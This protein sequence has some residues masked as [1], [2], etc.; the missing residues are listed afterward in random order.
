MFSILKRLLNEKKY[1]CIH[2]DE[3]SPNKFVFGKIIGV[4]TNNVAISMVSPDGEYDGVLL[5]QI[6]DI[7]RVEQSVSYENKMRKLMRMK[8]YDEKEFAIPNENIL[9]GILDFAKETGVIISVELDHSGIDDVAG[10][11]ES[12]NDK[13]CELIQVNEYGEEDGESF[14]TLSDISQICLD[15]SDE[16]RLLALFQADD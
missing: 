3:T 9:R 5:K 8:E 10:F 15:S 11:V 12:V 1:V 13:T 16:K 4:D 2:A 6:D 14:I 7:I